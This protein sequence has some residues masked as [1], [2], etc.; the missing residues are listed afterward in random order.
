MFFFFCSYV[1]KESLHFRKDSVCFLKESLYCLN[2]FHYFIFNYFQEL[3]FEEFLCFLKES[4]CFLKE[5][6][7]FLAFRTLGKHSKKSIKTKYVALLN[8]L[9]D[10]GAGKNYFLIRSLAIFY[11]NA[12]RIPPGPI[13]CLDDWMIG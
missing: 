11:S 8:F 6:L 4:L 1:L 10:D 3:K 13:G 5:S 9:Y 7:Y 12:P 2:Y